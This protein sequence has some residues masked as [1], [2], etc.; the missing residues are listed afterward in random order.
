LK[1]LENSFEKASLNK[2]Q[3]LKQFYFHRLCRWFRNVSVSNSTADIWFRCKFDLQLFRFLLL[4]V[5]TSRFV[6]SGLTLGQMATL[7][8]SGPMT[9]PESVISVGEYN[10]TGKIKTYSCHSHSDWRHYLETNTKRIWH[11]KSFSNFIIGS[12]CKNFFI[13]FKNVAGLWFQVSI[14][15]APSPGPTC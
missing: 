9:G 1:N 10:I 13:I 15:N 7:F 14:K 5:F 8:R 11:T 2:K 6:L 4:Q 12:T 3:Q